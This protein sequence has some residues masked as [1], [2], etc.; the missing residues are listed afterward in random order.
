VGRAHTEVVAVQ[1]DQDL[2]LGPTD[3]FKQHRDIATRAA[4]GGKRVLTRL[5]ALVIEGAL[6]PAEAHAGARFCRDFLIA[7]GGSLRSC[8]AI[9]G[10]KGL[11]E[12]A[13]ESRHDAFGRYSSAQAKIDLTKDLSGTK[14]D[15]SKVLLLFLIDECAFADIGRQA[16]VKDQT[17]KILVVK[18]LGVLA[19]FYEVVDR[20][21]GRND[22]PGSM[23]QVMR[24]IIPAELSDED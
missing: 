21:S 9:G 8:L 13:A 17:A 22:T 15:P 5:E 7:T 1:F 4:T 2:R 10:G 3:E 19:A 18:Y 20:R 6:T 24:I 23:D 12:D 16:G 11:A 14:I